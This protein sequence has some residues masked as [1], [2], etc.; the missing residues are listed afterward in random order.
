MHFERPSKYS[1]GNNG[2]VRRGGRV[3]FAKKLFKRL[4]RVSSKTEARNPFNDANHMQ[5]SADLRVISQVASKNAN[6]SKIAFRFPRKVVM[7]K[8]AFFAQSFGSRSHYS[9]IF[10]INTT[11][12]FD[13]YSHPSRS[14]NFGHRINVTTGKVLDFATLKCS[15]V[16][17]PRLISEYC[18]AFLLVKICTP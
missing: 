8:T 4:S 15:A 10:R 11:Q 18:L 7:L 13:R 1:N 16:F 14:R 5:I 12:L 2:F 9:V 3:C 17:S 6:A